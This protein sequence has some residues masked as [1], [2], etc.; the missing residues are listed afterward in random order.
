MDWGKKKMVN[1]R[2]RIIAYKSADANTTAAKKWPKLMIFV[3]SGSDPESLFLTKQI[4][5]R[6]NISDGL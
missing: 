2:K 6:S 3:V 1:Q 5:L 4:K